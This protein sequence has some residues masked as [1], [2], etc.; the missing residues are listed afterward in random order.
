MFARACFSIG[1]ALL[2]SS[3]GGGNTNS[4]VDS[5]G[6]RETAKT[7]VLEGGAAI[8]QGK[9]PVDAL[10]VYLNGF[11]FYNG[12]MNAQMEAHHYCTVVNEDLT[13][14]VIFDGNDKTSKLMGVEYIVSRNAFETLPPD[15]RK[16]WHSHNFEV[17]SGELVA[18]NIPKPAE[19]ALM[20]KIAS[21]YGKTWHTW[22]TD[23]G[24]KL[25]TGHPLLM[26]GFTAD[27]QIHQDMIADR[28]RRLSTSTEKEKENRSDI[29]TPPL[30]AGANSWQSGPILQLSLGPVT[31][32]AR[33]A[34]GG[35]RRANEPQPR[36]AGNR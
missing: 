21:T 10:N 24:R 16:L 8:L 32:E 6:H 34:M 9:P 14:C 17:N 22:N 18:P 35:G 29:R 19:H 26:M 33:A 11:H 23:Q 2:L 7:K 1:I 12:N 28:D 25:P 15:E 27:G 5:P 30:V 4:Y 13:Q 20:E 36:P 31:E 3:C